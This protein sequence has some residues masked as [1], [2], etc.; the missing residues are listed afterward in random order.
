MK[1]ASFTLRFP[2]RAEGRAITEMVV[3]RMQADGWV[4]VGARVSGD[5]T[6]LNFQREDE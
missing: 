4:F 1:R 2:S 6:V 5:Q 3:E